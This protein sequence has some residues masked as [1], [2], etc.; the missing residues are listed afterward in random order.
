MCGPSHSDTIHHT[1]VV[2]K[3][4]GMSA[5]KVSTIWNGDILRSV[6]GKSVKDVD[7]ERAKMEAASWTNMTMLGLTCTQATMKTCQLMQIIP[8]GFA[9]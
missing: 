9:F 5:S 1:Y 6:G 7:D 2:G 4:P 3:Q 8:D